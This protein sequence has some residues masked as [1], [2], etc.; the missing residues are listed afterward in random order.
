MYILQEYGV[1]M[2]SVEEMTLEQICKLLGKNVKIVK[3]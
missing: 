1:K 3:G 2:N